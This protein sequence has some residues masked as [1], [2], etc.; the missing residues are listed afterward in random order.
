M[1]LVA[2]WKEDPNVK[3][4]KVTFNSDGGTIVP[5]QKI[6]DGE[7]ATKPT[8]PTK[9]GFAFVDWTLNGTVYNFARPV[10]SDI[11]LKATWREIVPVTVTFDS[12][13][14]T[15]VPPQ[16]IEEGTKA[17][18]PASPTKTDYT[19]IEWRLDNKKYDFSK[20]VTK[21]ITL[22]AY[23]EKKLVVKFDSDGG[24]PTPQEQKIDKN[25][26]VTRPSDPTRSGY[27]FVEWIFNNTKY[28]FN[29]P[30][31]SDLTLKAYWEKIATYTLTFNANGGTVSP[32]SKTLTKGEQY[33]NLPTPTY[34]GYTFVGWYT[35]ATGGN[36]VNPS[37][38]I[39][40]N[41]TIYAHWTKNPVA[42]NSISFD[43]TTLS[44]NV[45][46]NYTLK[47][48]FNPTD[49]S[50]K[51]ITWSSSNTSVASVDGNGKVTANKA[52]TA[53]ITAT[54]NNGKKATCTVTVT[55]PTVAVTG[56]SLNK[57]SLTLTVGDTSTLT[58]TVS[59][60]NATNKNVSWS[61]SNTN[62]ATVDTSGKVTAKAAGTAT[63]TVT[64]V[65]GSKKATCNVTVNAAN[66]PVT[67][68]TLN[69]TSL[70][71][72]VGG[73]ETLSATVNPSNATNKGVTWSSSNTGVA[74][75]DSNGKVTAKAK[76]SATITVTT[77]DGHKTAT[78]SVNVNEPAATY[79]VTARKIQGGGSAINM[80]RKLTIKRNSTTLSATQIDEIKKPN[81]STFWWQ[82]DQDD[83]GDIIVPYSE[84]KNLSSLKIKLT[85]G[86]EVTASLSFPDD[87]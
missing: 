37:T 53:T 64:T 62:V 5:E 2:K 63:I 69:K 18:M 32:P 44:L 74:T 33:G 49:A 70:T 23:W 14:G 4:F 67:G 28:D 83:N 56:V 10:T 38:T 21:N 46:G 39:S 54:S 85:S 34:T 8:S 65:D 25:G 79:S 78:C 42:V 71:L 66:V 81:G 41:T 55:N 45:G 58:A 76:G 26:K 51:T 29:K 72:T 35:S 47:V 50:N 22:K 15:T 19:F 73:N 6:I 24:T 7:K 27:T 12:D 86:E 11:E 77:E 17:R 9:K 57:T 31:T 68:V 59:P 20:P 52:G 3:R 75:V 80:Q 61:S 43:R 36:V 13:G 1:K 16:E 48:T 84:I 30:V 60:S 82:G 40:S 87:N